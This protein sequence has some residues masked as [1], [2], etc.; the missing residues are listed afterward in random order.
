MAQQPNDAWR[1]LLRNAGAMAALIEDCR[2]LGLS[3]IV[4]ESIDFSDDGGIGFAE[5]RR[6]ERERD[7]EGVRGSAAKAHVGNDLVRSQEGDVLEKEPDHALALA[8][9]DTRV[10]PQTWKVGGKRQDLLTLLVVEQTVVGLS[11]LLVLLL[12]V[13][14]GTQLLVPVG[15]Q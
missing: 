12:R 10:S 9:R 1:K 3:V 15:L 2:N 14:Q 11:L 7:P 13:R 5:L 8:V 6:A 4:E